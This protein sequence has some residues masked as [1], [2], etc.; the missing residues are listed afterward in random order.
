MLAL[1]ENEINIDFRSKRF[2]QCSG[3]IPCQP[4][5]GFLSPTANLIDNNKQL[6]TAILRTQSLPGSAHLI[7]RAENKLYTTVNIGMGI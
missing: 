3:R 1:T 4:V 5:G 7:L 2:R 6:Y